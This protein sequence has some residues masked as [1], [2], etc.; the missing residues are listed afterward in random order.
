MA[1]NTTWHQQIQAVNPPSG[2]NYG[3]ELCDEEFSHFVL[4]IRHHI[5]E[6]IQEAAKRLQGVFI[7]QFIELS[8]TLMQMPGVAIIATYLRRKHGL[9]NLFVCSSL[10][11]FRE[12]LNQ[13][14]GL[15]EDVR[16][17]LILPQ[18][19]DFE[20]SVHHYFGYAGHKT[21]ACVEKKGRDVRIALID[22]LGDFPEFFQEGNK[23][24][25]FTILQYIKTSSLKKPKIYYCGVE[26]QTTGH[27]CESFAL[28]DAIA[29]LKDPQFFEKIRF[30]RVE[31]GMRE[32]KLLPPAFMKGTQK[33]ST[34]VRFG[35]KYLRTNRPNKELEVSDLHTCVNKHTVTVIDPQAKKS[36]KMQ[37]HYINHKSLKYHNILLKALE[38][39]S[40]KELSMIVNESLLVVPRTTLVSKL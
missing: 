17:A 4:R 34:L 30:K 2:Y 6:N 19:T 37:N 35:P 40:P 14:D 3:P 29:F 8:D 5:Q 24:S 10:E 15:K 32:I 12:K 25:S 16:C 31:S 21:V 33:S 7:E 13:I 39:T 26:R 36:R 22:A 9:K 27:S 38:T 1:A 11:A 18:E 28:R 20:K 23:T